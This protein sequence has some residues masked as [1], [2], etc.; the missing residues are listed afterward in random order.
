MTA[1][2]QPVQRSYGE[3]FFDFCKEKKGDLAKIM[4]Y[5]LGL[6]QESG[7]K[8]YILPFPGVGPVAHLPYWKGSKNFIGL[9]DVPEKCRAVFKAWTRAQ[10]WDNIAGGRSY[11]EVVGAVG[12][13]SSKV[14]EAL[15]V[16]NERLV[17]KTLSVVMPYFKIMGTFGSFFHSS[18]GTIKDIKDLGRREV[19][20]D[21]KLRQLTWL[22]L[23]RDSS[24]LA[25]GAINIIALK[26]TIAAH[27]AIVLVG[28]SFALAFGIG[29]Y[30]YERVENPKDDPKFY[31]TERLAAHV[32]Q[33]QSQ[34]QQLQT[35][36]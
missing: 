15:E 18:I 17:G 26:V 36:A 14:V 13:A 30:F 31:G 35:G 34:I 6:I 24:Y 22:K 19:Q 2:V 5:S 12:E 23:G 16:I 8:M 10:G 27:S 4:I 21:T 28:L 25:V 32:N 20:E 9:T 7:K 29:V 33:L 3:V 11:W 1:G